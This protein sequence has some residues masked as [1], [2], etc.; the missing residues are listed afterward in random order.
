MLRVDI[1]Q[2]MSEY[3]DQWLPGGV[4]VFDACSR[5]NCLILRIWVGVRVRVLSSIYHN[6]FHHS[7]P[8]LNH[9]PNRNLTLNPNPDPKLILT[10]T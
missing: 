5:F 4:I 1:E 10:L 9:N 8:N 2:L 6:R 3:E 7:K